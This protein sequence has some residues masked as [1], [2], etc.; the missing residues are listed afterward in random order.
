[1]RRY[2]ANSMTCFTGAS[3]HQHSP[4]QKQIPGLWATNSQ[5]IYIAW[6]Q[7]FLTTW[8]IDLYK[9]W[10]AVFFEEAPFEWHKLLLIKILTIHAK[11]IFSVNMAAGWAN[12]VC[13]RFP[14]NML[15]LGVYLGVRK[16][17]T[18]KKHWMLE[19]SV[20]SAHVLRIK[21][22]K[23]KTAKLLVS[24]T[25]TAFY[26]FPSCLEHLLFIYSV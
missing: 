18:E 3:K 20:S 24:K 13:G 1:M 5:P 25:L 7:I 6:E 15:A 21:E 12:G 11:W 16:N 10:M 9:A 8:V 19:A 22:E 14:G 26:S 23:K 4:A 2:D 17:N